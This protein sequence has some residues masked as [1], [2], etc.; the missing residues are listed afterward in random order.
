MILDDLK[1][2]ERYYHAHPL[3][4]QAFDFLQRGEFVPGRHELAGKQLIA[5]CESGDGKTRAAA[6]LEAHRKYIDIQYTVS[7]NEEIGWKAY[8]DCMQ[9]KQPYNPEKDIEFFFEQPDL[10]LPVPKNA[11]AIFFPE[12][13]AHAPLA[14]TEHVQKVIMK[15]AVL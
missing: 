6:P 5:I 2:A 11:F 3:F 9:I 14:G 10:W 8:G 15:V 13:D 12:E 4:K 7:G 1:R